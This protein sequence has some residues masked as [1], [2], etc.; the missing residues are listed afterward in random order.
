MSQAVARK[1]IASEDAWYEASGGARSRLTTIKAPTLIVAGAKDI[2]VPSA[3][4]Q[5][6]AGLIPDA[7]VA[8]VSAA[9]HAVLMQAHDHF[10]GELRRFL[11]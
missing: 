4:A 11:G 6:L 10:L 7:R 2:D 3:N 9:G 1:V 5:L 8:I